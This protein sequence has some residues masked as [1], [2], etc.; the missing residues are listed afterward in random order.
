MNILDKIVAHKKQEVLT[1]K[2][3]VS[4]KKLENEIY[5]TRATN[6]LKQ[7]FIN[8]NIGIIAEFKR[9]SPSKGIIN[10]V[11]TPLDVV[12][13]YEQAGA[14]ASSILTDSFFFGGQNQDIL[15][16]RDSVSIPILRKEFMIDEYQI[17]EAKAIGADVILLIAAIL[18][19]QEIKSFTTLA[20]QLGLEVLLELHDTEELDKI[21][22]DVDL[23]GINNRNL[24]TFKVDIE[25]SIKMSDYLQNDFIKIAESGLSE[26]ATVKNLYQ[27][28]FKGFL[29]GENFM[30]TENPALSC[31]NFIAQID[32]N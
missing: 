13:G 7:Q 12:L 26:V 3:K 16:V 32:I 4:I 5:F 9:Q 18:T 20:H 30:K 8:K 27:A 31:K 21:D 10:D 2:E 6:S 15:E 29:M 1:A 28:G 11:V 14:I 23:I 22:I 17:V 19:K 24:K 25:H